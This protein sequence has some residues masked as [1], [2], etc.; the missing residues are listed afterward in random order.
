VHSQQ[1]IKNSDVTFNILVPQGKIILDGMQ[2][3]LYLVSVF[4]EFILRLASDKYIDI[5]NY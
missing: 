2:R 4:C 5:N 3:N 1:N